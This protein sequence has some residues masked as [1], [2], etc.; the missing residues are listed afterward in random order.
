MT[1]YEQIE[2]KPM[3]GAL[4]AEIF[5][6]DISGPLDHAVAKELRR[7]F[8]EYLVIVLRDQTLQ[9]ESQLCFA[10]R[11]GE[12][13]IYPFVKGLPDFPE[14]T[15]V[16]KETDDTINFGGLWH[17]DT[18]YEETPP[19][20]TMLYAR[21]LPPIGGDTQFA[22]MYLAYETLSDGMKCMLES[23][24][25]INVSGKGRVQNTRSAMRKIAATEKS[26]DSYKA[27]HP[28][29]RTHPETGRKSLYVNLA[30]T[31]HFKGMTV[32][33]SAPVLDYLFRHQTR[34]EFTCRLKWEVGTLAFWDNRCAQHNPLNDYH[35]YR[36]EMHR[37]TL[38]GDKPN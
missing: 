16:V 17:T 22:N 15:P 24:V 3:T 28:A 14:V 12:P 32:E 1:G 23:L 31:S 34:P 38:R 10:S 18:A 33:E 13:M 35:G 7:A 20:G 25:G 29:V 19:L 4:G 9:P 8:L 5:G 27:E 36:R 37:V 21:E 26:E 30:H 6:L 2:V 11:F